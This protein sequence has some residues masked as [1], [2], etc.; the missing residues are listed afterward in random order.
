MTEAPIGARPKDRSLA[1]QVRATLVS[2]VIVVLALTGGSVAYLSLRA[3]LAAVVALQRERSRAAAI[4]IDAYFEDLLRKIGY[5]SR[6]RGLTE[7]PREQ[8]QTLLEGLLRHNSAY[9]SVALADRSGAIVT[10]VTQHADARVFAAVAGQPAFTRARKEGEDYVGPVEIDREASRRFLIA[11]VPVRDHEDRI[12]GV[13]LARL[14]LEF[15]AY[16]VSQVSVGETGY[17]YVVDNRGFVIARRGASAEAFGRM[18]GSIVL[19]SSDEGRRYRGLLGA[20]VV[21]A[22]SAVRS[23][24]WTVVVELPTA[25]A[26]LPLRASALAIG[27]ALTMGALAALAMG[28]WFSRQVVAPI[29]QLTEAAAQVQRG[30]LE[31]A[32]TIDRRNELGALGQTFNVMTRKLRALVSSLNMAVAE[33]D[34]LLEAEHEARARIEEAERRATFLA[35]IGAALAETL[36]VN[37]I[38]ARL[39]RTAVPVVA[40][41]CVIDLLGEDGTVRRP[42][43]VHADPTKAPLLSELEARYPA[44]LETVQPA[45]MAMRSGRTVLLTDPQRTLEGTTRSPEHAALLRAIGV[46]AAMAVPLAARGRVLGAI[47][48]CSCSPER[49]YGPADVAMC[50]ELARRAS[51]A[52][53]NAQLFERAHEA[54][55]ARDLFLSVASHEL[56]GPI[57]TLQLRL[58]AALRTAPR[59]LSVQKLSG[60]LAVADRQVQKLADLVASLLDLS[61][62]AAGRLQLELEL[63]DLCEVVRDVCQRL[64]PEGVRVGSVLELRLS[65]EVMGRWDRLRL[66]QVVSNLVGNA[67]RYAG[68]SPVEIEVA[69]EG[70]RARLRVRDHGPGIPP[71]SRS[72]IFERF[73]RSTSEA[74]SGGLG[75]GLYIVRQI[76]EAHGGSISLESEIGVGST[77]TVE[78]PRGSA[79]DPSHGQGLT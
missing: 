16:V 26:F 38:V 77:F 45:A 63:V 79:E 72:R 50:E 74:R 32:V 61:R 52:I 34:R 46:R 73:E 62:I 29:E 31:A 33:R 28:V 56:R 49:G 13:L 58:Q 1:R 22:S 71:E 25:E 37:E 44:Q 36:D 11:A 7:L 51:L 64:E 14:D 47:T 55:R 6:V 57:T 23:A 42:A 68:G 60:T 59:D 66:E 78:L 76:V 5:L 70:A 75:L 19:G 2:F 17:A 9:E 39:A 35:S 41:M 20:N 4:E 67:F 43:A 10:Q 12:D 21:G 24:H 48:L 8:Q 18:D 53:D 15:L 69:S 3:H 40:D 54:V 65:G 30:D 27:T